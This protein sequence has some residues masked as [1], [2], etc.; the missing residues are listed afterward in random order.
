MAAGTNQPYPRGV[1]NQLLE[2]EV[3]PASN[4]ITYQQM[5]D[6][7]SSLLSM[8]CNTAATKSRGCALNPDLY[9]LSTSAQLSQAQCT[10]NTT[11]CFA[12]NPSSAHGACAWSSAVSLEGGAGGSG[13]RITELC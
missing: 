8:N 3:G 5:I 13:L 4:R 2:V 6:T 12:A 10:A 1:S 11:G 9:T 7:G